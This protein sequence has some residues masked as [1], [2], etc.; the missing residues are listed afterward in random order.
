MNALFW[1]CEK[2]NEGK[3]MWD[4][5][6]MKTVASLKNTGYLPVRDSKGRLCYGGSQTFWETKADEKK[7]GLIVRSGCGL[8]ACCDTELYLS[9]YHDKCRGRLNCV[10]M[11]DDAVA[12]EDYGKL[13]E[14]KEKQRYPLKN[15]PGKLLNQVDPW[16]MEKGLTKFYRENGLSYHAVWAHG[17]DPKKVN[18]NILENLDQNIP[19]VA[20]FCS[21]FTRRK[22]LK[23]G[24]RFYT[25]EKEWQNVKSH[26]FVITGAYTMYDSSRNTYDTWYAVS[27]W[28][29]KYYICAEEFLSSLNYTTN[30][31][32]T[33][34]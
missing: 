30:I 9:L 31:L 1:T 7:A 4:N 33:V 21:Y 29:R 17:K 6:K 26:Y 32:H 2:G 16:T 11:I 24:I 19:V 34:L 20:S 8:I 14:L 10:N 15:R 13:V 18:R 25:N 27:S 5:N 12:Y 28:G 23:N 22:D 3:N